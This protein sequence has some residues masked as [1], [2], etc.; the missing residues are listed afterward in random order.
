MKPPAQPPDDDDYV[1]TEYVRHDCLEVEPG[2]GTLILRSSPGTA[3]RARARK[4][5]RGLFLSKLR[6]HGLEVEALNVSD[7]NS[8]AEQFLDDLYLKPCTMRTLPAMLQ[9]G[10]KVDAYLATIIRREVEEAHR[11]QDP[12]GH[13]IY[14]IFDQA[15]KRAEQ[16]Q[17]VRRR[18]PK[19][20]FCS[21]NVF[22][23]SIIN[24]GPHSDPEP[25]PRDQEELQYKLQ[26]LPSWDGLLRLVLGR[27]SA[28]S[29]YKA[30][31]QLLQEMQTQGVR[32]VHCGEFLGAVKR[33]C[34]AIQRLPLWESEPQ[35]EPPT[36]AAARA[37]QML[38][39]LATSHGDEAVARLIDEVRN[40]L[41]QR[42]MMLKR[43]QRMVSLT[44]RFIKVALDPQGTLPSCRN[45][46]AE[47]QAGKSVVNDDI[48]LLDEIL[49]AVIRVTSKAHSTAG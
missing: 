30:L 34:E 39:T 29:R 33:G 28:E 18:R 13:R 37:L 24:Q 5:V 27:K 7:S 43:R 23:L 45:L 16:H 47:F 20:P 49:G 46:A 38:R 25:P 19:A 40:E 41:A 21:N 42:N 35:E 9:Q 36:P 3:F 15:L 17:Q 8:L 4:K 1:L 32:E 12:L 26:Q 11:K 22:E 2:T 10:R 14:E 48:Q 6:L 31:V 44:D